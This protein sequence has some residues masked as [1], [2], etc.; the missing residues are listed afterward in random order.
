MDDPD[1]VYKL[2]YLIAM[3]SSDISI[4]DRSYPINDL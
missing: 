1:C 4:N 3:N 2:P